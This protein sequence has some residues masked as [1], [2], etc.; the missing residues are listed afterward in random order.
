MTTENQFEE[1]KPSLDTSLL[2][3][4]ST[5]E[6]LIE[7][8][9]PQTR[10]QKILRR[11]LWTFFTLFCFLLFTLMKLPEDRI[12]N[13]IDGSLNLIL[14]PRGISISSSD[15]HLS[16]L[17]GI[18]YVMKDVTLVIPPPAVPIH[19]EKIEVSPSI[20]P[21]LLGKLGGTLHIEQG[22]GSM[23]GSFSI[24]N[25]QISTSGKFK[26][27]DIGKSGLLAIAA[28]IQGSAVLDG[29]L[30][31]SGDFSVPQ[32]IEGNTRLHLSH[33]VLEPQ[34][35]S[36]F[37]IP[38][39]NISEGTFDLNIAKGKALIKTLQLG[40]TGGTPDD[41][42]GTLTGD[43]TLAKQWESSL[44]NLKSHFS[45]SETM[46]KSFMILDLILSAGK[47]PD[48]SFAFSLTG[49]LDGPFPSPLTGGET[50]APT[51]TASPSGSPS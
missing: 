32:S 26:K 24:K 6:S 42:R 25:T 20:L 4:P 35:I 29:E 13:Y 40:K 5:E 18:S 10:G 22:S 48:G 8:P 21:L 38:R 37:S 7:S 51:P 19:I 33:I 12:K 9:P 23:K 11:T 14:K 31:L 44:L 16:Y 46:L 36:G 47:Q 17:F 50:P 43:I 1:I 3:A 41:L 49:P 2:N 15:S 34:S 27:F 28:E 39:L 30:D 45:L